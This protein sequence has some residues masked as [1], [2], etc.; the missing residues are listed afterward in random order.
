[1]SIHKSFTN[2]ITLLPSAP[3]TSGGSLDVANGQVG[4]FLKGKRTSRGIGAIS[5]VVNLSGNDKVFIEVGTGSKGNRGSLTNKNM[6]TIEFSPKD[7]LELKFNEAQEGTTSAV[8]I[9]Y[10]NHDTTRSLTLKPG[11]AA[12]ITLELSGDYVSFFGKTDGKFRRTYT[13]D[14]PINDSCEETDF[15]STAVMKPIIEDLVK[16]IKNDLFVSGVP[17]SELLDVHGIYSDA[18]ATP[19]DTATFYSLSLVDSGDDNALGLVQATVPGVRVVR[20]ERT[21]LTS[22]YQLV[23][24]GAAPS[25][26]TPYYPSVLTNCGVCPDDYV[27]SEGGFYYTFS[28]EDDGV[29]VKNNLFIGTLAGLGTPTASTIGGEAG[30]TYTAVATTSDGDGTGATLTIVRN[31]SGAVSTVTI[32]A[33][34]SGYKVGD[35]ITVAGTAIGGAAPADNLTATVTALTGLN[36]IT[37]VGQEYGVGKYAVLLDNAITAA[38]VAAIVADNPTFKQYFN[39]EVSDVCIFDGTPVTTSWVE[40]EECGLITEDYYIDIKDNDCGENILA[41]LQAE[42]PD[43]TIEVDGDYTAPDDSCMTRYKTSVVS[44]IVCSECFPN[45][46]ITS[47]PAEYRN[48]SWIKVEGAASDNTVLTG[49]YLK[50]KDFVLCPDKAIADQVQTIVEPMEIQVSGGELTGSKIGYSYNENSFPVRRLGRAFRG[51]GY[52]IDYMCAEKETQ[53]RMLG[54]YNGGGY[55]EAMFKDMVTKLQPCEKYDTITLKVK[56]SQFNNA[57]SHTSD[58]YVRYVFVIPQGTKGLYASFFN[59]VA[60]ANPDAGNI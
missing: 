50:P 20:T 55:V 30:N 2:T 17:L 46:Y 42:Y 13:F 35:V 45:D 58:E 3:F 37:K 47:A 41:E 51:S 27:A 40:G 12:Q 39:G 33:A 11:Q 60:A 59:A 34:G 19:T 49:I 8:I 24:T 31:G 44:N 1:M 23:T 9:G 56:G 26:Y 28:V 29:D 14:A 6:K 53:A 18:D 5:S 16:R 7:V 43:L 22:V 38:Q 21:G 4:L 32:V 15:C 36:S 25:D 10:D 54:L 57:F 52:G 48:E